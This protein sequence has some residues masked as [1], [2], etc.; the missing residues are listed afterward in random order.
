MAG[1]LSAVHNKNQ[2]R[3]SHGQCMPKSQDMGTLAKDAGSGFPRETNLMKNQS[4]RFSASPAFT[5]QNPCL[6][7]AR[8]SA[9]SGA[10]GTE[11]RS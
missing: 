2:G 11:A 8:G 1:S 6:K 5:S 9:P 3:I 7:N 4:N 10:D